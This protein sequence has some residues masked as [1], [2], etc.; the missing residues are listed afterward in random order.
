MIAG[1]AAEGRSRL[2]RRRIGGYFRGY[3]PRL[4]VRRL[5]V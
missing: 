4:S 1:A 5:T 3:F 2:V